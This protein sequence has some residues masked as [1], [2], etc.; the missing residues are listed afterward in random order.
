MKVRVYT[1]VALSL[2]VLVAILLLFVDLP[3]SLRKDERQILLI[4]PSEIDQLH[5][6]GQIDTVRLTRTGDAWQLPGEEDVN[7]VAVE[8][9][10][11]AAQRLQVDA[12]HTH[13]A[14][15][16]T[17]SVR[18]VS[19]MSRGK[20]V[21]QYETVGREGRFL[22]RFPGSESSFTVSLPGYPELDLNRVFSASGN[23]FREHMLI[24]LLPSEIRLIEVEKRGDS[25]FRF[26]MDETGN[27]GCELPRS[28]SLVPMEL[29]DEVSVRLLFTYFTSIRFEGTAADMD[30]DMDEDEMKE[31]WLATLYVESDEGEKHSLKVCSIPGEDGEKEHIFRALVTHNNSPE[32]LVIN[33]IYLDVLMRGLSAYIGDN[34]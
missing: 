5:I 19:F 11:F 16:N 13:L 33:Y 22:L 27:I 31:R 29:L 3:G 34:L 14:E 15:W 24:D 4:D 32:P 30:V 1:G 20:T 21:L 12:V 26:S 6:A 10:L 9:I 23:H 2:L 8:N 18:K 28:D 17:G 25:P 7:P